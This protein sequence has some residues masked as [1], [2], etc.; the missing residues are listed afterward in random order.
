MTDEPKEPFMRMEFIGERYRDGH[1]DT[2][3]MKS[4]IALEKLLY[5]IGKGLWQKDNPGKRL[6]KG[7]K[8]M[9]KLKIT[10]L[11]KGD[12]EDRLAAEEAE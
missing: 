1:L 2:D 5:S 10:S 8:K 12:G 9:F 4:I 7:F 11:T 3:A 6:P